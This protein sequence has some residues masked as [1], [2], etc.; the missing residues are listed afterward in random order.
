MGL[1]SPHV[2]LPRWF[3][4]GVDGD[5]DLEEPPQAWSTEAV[6]IFCQMFYTTY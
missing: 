6:I 2:W 5:S 3:G 4:K 1:N